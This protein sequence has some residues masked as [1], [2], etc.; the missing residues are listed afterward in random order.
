MQQNNQ[1]DIMV[2]IR[3]YA[4]VAF[5]VWICEFSV[6]LHLHMHAYDWIGPRHAQIVTRY[7]HTFDVRYSRRV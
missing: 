7:C 6:G 5:L 4:C 2:R 3:M 1:A